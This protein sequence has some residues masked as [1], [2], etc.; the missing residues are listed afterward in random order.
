MSELGRQHQDF[1]GAERL[2]DMVL[3]VLSWSDRVAAL[4]ALERAGGD[5]RENGGICDLLLG[6]ISVGRTVK[7]IVACDASPPAEPGTKPGPDGGHLPRG[8]LR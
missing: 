4:S 5:R 7:A 3:G 6:I 1:A 8:I 2:A